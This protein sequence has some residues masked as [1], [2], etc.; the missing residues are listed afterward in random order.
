[1]S[2]KLLIFVLTL[3]FLSGAGTAFATPP[4]QVETSTVNLNQ[5]QGFVLF[6]E[7]KA[8]HDGIGA[9]QDF[10]KAR[11]LYLAAADLGNTQALINLGYLYF[12]GQGVRPDLVKARA[13]YELA[14]ER[15]NADAI[16]NLKMM[17]A[18][19]LGILPAAKP[20]EATTAEAPSPIK[21]PAPA[22]AAVDQAVSAAKTIQAPVI[23][24]VVTAPTLVAP[25]IKDSDLN[26]QIEEMAAKPKDVNTM[27]ANAIETKASTSSVSKPAVSKPAVSKPFSHSLSSGL[28]KS[29][30][31]AV[32]LMGLGIALIVRYL[33]LLRNQKRD[34]KIRERFVNFF[35][36]AKRSDLRLTYLRRRSEGFVQDNFYREWHATL[37]VLMARYALTFNER[38]E[39]LQAFCRK[40]ND[41][42]GQQLRPT[43]HLAA[44]YSDRMMQAA[45]T[46]VKAVDAFHTAKITEKT[47]LS[48]WNKLALPSKSRPRKNVVNIFRKKNA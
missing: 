29:D 26:I 45:R 41:G 31:F 37:T 10:E 48:S 28:S 16:Q 40:L 39:E 7:G 6:E 21:A 1:V 43:Q 12:T 32:V 18:R 17:D 44:E 34:Q 38:D 33:L 8:A 24:T 3:A 35:Y 30:K 5:Q 19:G 2:R 27:E 36:E 46:E 15:G 20:P 14:A 22:A 4:T 9:P 42:L 13:F 23:Q 47:S 11:F 25:V